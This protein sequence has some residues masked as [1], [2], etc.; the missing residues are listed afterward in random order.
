MLLV[1][2]DESQPRELDI[3]L[4]QLVGA[5]DEIDPA[6]G[7]A[8]EHGLDFLRGAKARQLGQLDRQIGETIREDLQ[9]LLGQQGCRHQ[10]RDLLAI[11]DRDE[12]G[13]QRDFRLAEAHVAADEAVHRFAGD[14]ILDDR[15]DRGG[16]I[17]VSSN[18][19]PSAKAS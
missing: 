19:K 7:Y 16:L 8:F 4:D 11:G 10:H 1:D 3:G 13:A 6:V 2:D 18:P 15:F 17:G 12:R 14:E 9:M 5:D